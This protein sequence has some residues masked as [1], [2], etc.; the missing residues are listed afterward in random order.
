M[1]RKQIKKKNKKGKNNMKVL[2]FK[3]G[4]LGDILKELHQINEHEK[5]HISQII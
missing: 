5:K 3:I 4:K 2:Y 1:I